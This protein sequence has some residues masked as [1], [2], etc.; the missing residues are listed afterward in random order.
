MNPLWERFI[1][2]SEERYIFAGGGT[3][4]HLFPAIA[5]ADAIRKRKPGAGILFIGTKD[6]IESSVVP[7][8]GYEFRAIWIS[9]FHRRKILTNLL[10]PLKLVVSVMQSIS[11]IRKYKPS[12][13]V[14]TG[15]FV[16]GPVVYAATLL[17]VPSLI[18]DQNGVPGVTTRILGNRVNEVH[19]TFES[20]R[21]Y[22]RR[23]DGVF[24]SGNPTREFSASIDRVA[25][26]N[27]F[28]FSPSDTRKTILIF[29][30]SL[31]ATTINSAVLKE[32]DTVLKNGVRVIWQ[33]GRAD[34]QRVKGHPLTPSS[35]RSGNESLWVGVF[36][37]RM[38]YAYSLSDLVVCRAGATT[39]AE[40]TCLGKPSVLVPYPFAAA[41]HQVGNA[42][43][44][45]EKNAALVIDDANAGDELIP[46]ALELL[47]NPQRLSA[48]AEES[49]KL[50]KPNAANEIADHI[51]ALAAKRV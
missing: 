19:L 50:G 33:T 32:I 36:I 8:R 25:A 29:G 22:F 24:M 26:S 5:I 2:V 4:G 14:G 7:Q 42:K 37:D 40:L 18:Q 38:D 31:G 41:N 17:G 27:C 12:V 44:L 21:K 49:K 15:G 20:S 39:I 47:S 34:Y 51:L 28:G 1:D 43:G 10:F 30:G 13:V 11:I 3:G 35:E 16:S 46:A 23:N 45:A 6:K 48:M 9:G